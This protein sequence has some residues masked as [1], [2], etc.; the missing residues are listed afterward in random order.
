MSLYR[1][2]DNDVSAYVAQFHRPRNAASTPVFIDTSGC[3]IIAKGVSGL[4][5]PNIA[6][7]IEQL[8]L[9]VS[10]PL[11]IRRGIVM[12]YYAIDRFRSDIG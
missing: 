10:G 12:G 4:G 5:D 1:R 6:G 7:R 2:F 9:P 11:L 8:A 3:E